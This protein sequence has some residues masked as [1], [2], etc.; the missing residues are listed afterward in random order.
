MINKLPVAVQSRVDAHL[1]A[2]EKQLQAAGADRATRR[3]VVD[4]LETQ[5]VDMLGSLEAPTP[6]VTDFDEV[7][8]RLD[9]PQAYAN[10]S[11]WPS[12]RVLRVERGIVYEPRLCRQAKQGA[13]CI[14]LGI[15]APLLL[16]FGLKTPP[17]LHFFYWMELS[18]QEGT[19]PPPLWSVVLVG[20]LTITAA[21]AAVALPIAGT[22]L[23]W[24]ATERIR[25][26]GGTQ[27]GLGLGVGEAL[28]YPI[29]LV[30]FVTFTI[31]RQIEQVLYGTTY[32]SGPGGQQLIPSK[33]LWLF[34]TTVLS[35]G[36]VWWLRWSTSPK[37]AASSRPKPQNGASSLLAPS[38]Q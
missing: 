20:A 27:Y 5:I 11:A 15:L 38:N 23:G 4:D 29:L 24:T 13:W 10:E 26:S 30:W 16:V 25:R 31:D 34:W 36:L 22:L 14:G 17:A 28:L 3:N 32:L 18:L 9:P 37:R 12:D 33:L 21:V 19:P 2:V 7:L 8:G 35:V 1:D 6:T